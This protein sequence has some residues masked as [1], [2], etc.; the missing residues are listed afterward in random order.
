MV[1]IQYQHN[2]SSFELDTVSSKVSKGSFSMSN[3][4]S[5]YTPSSAGPDAATVNKHKNTKPSRSSAPIPQQQRPSNISSA[6]LEKQAVLT[7]KLTTYAR[8]CDRR[9]IL[10]LLGSNAYT[11]MYTLKSARVEDI[12]LAEREASGER[13]VLNGVKFLQVRGSSGVGEY[14]C[15]RV[16]CNAHKMLRNDQ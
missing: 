5:F 11:K 12:A 7:Q 15:A 10:R 16:T 13:G 4:Y 1:L 6:Q 3:R 8:G 9:Q 14:C 2:S